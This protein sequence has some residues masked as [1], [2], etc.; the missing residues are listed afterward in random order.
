MCMAN[1]KQAALGQLV[2]ANDHSGSNATLF[3][4]GVPAKDGGLRELATVQKDAVSFY[5]ALSNEIQSPKILACPAERKVVPADDFNSLTSAGISYFLNVDAT[6]LQPSVALQGDAKL[7]FL[8]NTP[9]KPVTLSADSKMEWDRSVHERIGKGVGNLAL[10][11]GSVMRANP[12]E[13]REAFTS[14]AGGTIAA[15][16]LIP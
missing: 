5:V 8:M 14:S 2:W 12:P 16:F 11:D 10:S 9:A 6:T 15:R 1:L 3:A 13:L 4:A 7:S